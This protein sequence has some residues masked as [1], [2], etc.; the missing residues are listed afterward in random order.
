LSILLMVGLN[1]SLFGLSL[2]HLGFTIPFC[3]WLLIGFF[4]SVP[5]EVAEAAGLT[6]A[7][8]MILG[9]A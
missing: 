9:T 2:A 4:Q 6:L 7:T 1:N 8:P 3:T 5:V